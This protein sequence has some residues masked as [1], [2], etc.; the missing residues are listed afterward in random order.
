M[1]AV[2]FM[3]S[4]RSVTLSGVIATV[5]AVGLI[6]AVI[7]APGIGLGFGT[8]TTQSSEGTMAVLL[9][10][11]P[12]VPGNVSA[13]Y[14]Q[15]SQVQA[16]VANSGNQS[17]WQDLTGSEEINLMSVVNVS[18]TIANSNLPAG[19]FNGL[20]F[21]VTQ[22]TVTYSP[23]P[24]AQQAQNYTG[25]MIHGHNTLYV[26]IPGGINVVA[27]QT[28]AAMI[29]LTPTVVLAGSTS[30]PTFI[31]IPSARGYVIPSSS[32]PA[33]SH[34]IGERSDLAE[35]SWWSGIEAG[36]K[37]AITYVSLSATS[38]NVTVTNQGS[39]SVEIRL[40]GVTTQTTMSGGMESMLKTSDIF[41]VQSNGTMVNLNTTS[42]VSVDDQVAA[43][44]LLLA[45]GQRVTLTFKG[46]VLI[47]A[48]IQ[49][50]FPKFIPPM[51][52]PGSFYMV[53]VQGNGQ[54]A[55]AGTS[56]K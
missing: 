16:H 36:T 6:I 42:A 29:D 17:G 47:G 23:N 35:N 39:S 20:R 4:V 54:I 44:G 21:N 38:L 43:G 3:S 1:L 48:Q 9:T 45:P 50:M 41:A 46:P 19:Q 53:W 15:Y 2:T 14:I 55:Q 5:I 31:F 22:I 30:N 7:Y 34:A 49:I 13:V 26:W 11:P 32:I 51:V 8:N 24:T 25:L 18:Q 37:F 12:T 52:A 28:A 56:A 40:A 10:D 27:A 33:Q